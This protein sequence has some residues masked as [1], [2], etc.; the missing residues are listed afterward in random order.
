MAL[1]VERSIV[2]YRD[3]PALAGQDAGLDAP[4]EK[5]GAEASAVIATIAQQF[6]RLREIWQK[7]GSAFVVIGLARGH[8]Q[9]DQ[10]TFLVADGMQLGIRSAAGASDAP[11]SSPF[12]ARLAA[13]RCALRRVL[14]TI[15]RP[16]TRACATRA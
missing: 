10:P 16:G 9:P 6:A 8:E 3:L 2:R 13:G 14:S 15:G 7:C 11:W 4:L 12:F 5:V 1:P